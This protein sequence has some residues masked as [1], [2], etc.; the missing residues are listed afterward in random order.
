MEEADVIKL[1]KSQSM[2]S[3]LSEGY[4]FTNEFMANKT[5]MTIF[6]EIATKITK[7]LYVQEKEFYRGRFVFW[8]STYEKFIYLLF[9]EYTEVSSF[10]YLIKEEDINRILSY[11]KIAKITVDTDKRNATV[12]IDTNN[13]K[14]LLPKDIAENFF[15]E[16]SF[17]IKINEDK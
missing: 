15:R 6:C 2:F 9:V 1:L 10:L 17:K 13:R 8:G 3:E 4:F 7:E 11:W 16:E 5:K 14:L 12:E